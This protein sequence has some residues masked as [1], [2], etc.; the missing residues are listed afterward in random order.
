MIHIGP[1]HDPFG[2]FGNMPEIPKE[3]LDKM[4]NEE[5]GKVG[6]FY[7]LISLVTFIVAISIGLAV[8]YWTN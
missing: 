7:T 2:Y 6:C 3:M 1:T 4:S 5:R 8:C